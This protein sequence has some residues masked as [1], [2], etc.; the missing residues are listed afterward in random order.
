[1]FTKEYVCLGIQIFFLLFSFCVEM[2]KI[3]NKL[4]SCHP[5]F[6]NV[7]AIKAFKFNLVQLFSISNI[8]LVSI[9]FLPSLPLL[10]Y[11]CYKHQLNKLCKIPLLLTLDLLI[12][13]VSFC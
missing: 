2:C 7:W 10:L 6:S 8:M 9:T 3:T 5:F 1:M 13:I 12:Y 4:Q 11:L